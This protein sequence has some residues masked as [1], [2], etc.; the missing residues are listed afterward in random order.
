[1]ALKHPGCQPDKSRYMH[2]EPISTHK[3][4][5]VPPPRERGGVFG[6]PPT[7]NFQPPTP[8][9]QRPNTK[10]IPVP[11]SAVPRRTDAAD[12]TTRV[13]FLMVP[14]VLVLGKVTFCIRSPGQ[15]LKPWKGGAGGMALVPMT[16]HAGHTLLLPCNHLLP[17][18]RPAEVAHNPDH[19]QQHNA[20]QQRCTDDEPQ[21]RRLYAQA[22]GR[23]SARAGP[24]QRRLR[25][26]GGQERGRSGGGA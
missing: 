11:D 14:R 23:S 3:P 24:G 6:P 15:R 22:R 18:L 25:G 4:K 8:P 26:A 21:Q 2:R 17:A 19:A 12:D 1:M 13:L 10:H 7:Q 9:S 5:N 20:R 16:L